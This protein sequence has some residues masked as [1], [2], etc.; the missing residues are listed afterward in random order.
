[1]EGLCARGRQAGIEV[2]DASRAALWR[3]SKTERPAEILALVGRDPHAP[4]EEVLS[5]CGATWLLVGIAYPGNTGFAI[6]TAE[7]SGADGVFIDSDF[8]HEGRREAVRAAMRADRF[9]PVF[10]MPALPVVSAARAAG[11]RVLAIEDV[12]SRAP[13]EMD[14]GGPVL[15]VVGGE[16]HGI[17]AEVLEACDEAI[18]IP[19][20]GCGRR[21]PRN[22]SRGVGGV[23]RGDP[24]PD[25]GIHPLLQ[26]AGGHGRSGLRTPPP[27]LGRLSRPATPLTLARRLPT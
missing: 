21:T 18:R 4:M 27:A 8:E 2:Q 22:P 10:W 24:H 25:A 3:L 12:G 11:R 20:L 9:M 26:P 19:M 15:F 13:W 16:R 6:R 14:L 23:R 17:P 1:V 7:V 5:A